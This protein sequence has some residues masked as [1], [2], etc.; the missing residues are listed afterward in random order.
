MRHFLPLVLIAILFLAACNASGVGPER[1]PS[2]ESTSVVLSGPTATL[3]QPSPT[4]PP[5]AIPSP[6]T[7]IV[8]T[9]TPLSTDF[10]AALSLTDHPPLNSQGPYILS[11]AL[12]LN[13]DGSAP[14][15]TLLLNPDGSG[16]KWISYPDEYG[17]LSFSPDGEWR[18]L[19]TGGY[20]GDAFIGGE[21][22]PGGWPEISLSLLHIP[23]G[24]IIKVATI[25]TQ[26]V[27]WDECENPVT[28]FIRVRWSPDSRYLAFIANPTNTSLDLFV[29]D[30]E[31]GLLRQLTND[32]GD[33]LE[34]SWLPDGKHL[35]YTNGFHQEQN[36]PLPV[37]GYHGLLTLNMIGLEDDPSQ[38]VRTLYTGPDRIQTVWTDGE[39]GF[40]YL[41]T[42]NYYCMSAMYETVEL[43]YLNLVT[44]EKTAIWTGPDITL[45]AIDPADRVILLSAGGTYSVVKFNGKVDATLESLSDCSAEIPYF[46]NPQN[47]VL[48]ISADKKKII[49]TSFGCEVESVVSMPD[50][51]QSMGASPDQKWL[52]VDHSQGI[53][54]YSRQG[55]LIY[56]WPQTKDISAYLWTPD[57]K[58]VYFVV[59]GKQLYYWPFT[60]PTPSQIFECPSPTAPYSMMCFWGLMWAPLS[61]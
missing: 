8:S 9:E 21:V 30:T 5:T 14:R 10:P 45:Q 12:L 15:F 18:V 23:D 46:R 47:T 20:S 28:Y 1:T 59:E 34:I 35:S 3:I 61:P 49:G 36:N 38:G 40:I 22:D 11:D 31:S 41:T 4:L 57:G 58:G 24:N 48:S 27:T 26:W 2:A 7:A 50:E 55:V 6:T 51:I 39:S 56:N 32:A 44:G 52:V 13:P 60:D 25:A 42:K 33:V 19:F 37:S 53:D 43:S 29:Y 16:L 17:L 54:L